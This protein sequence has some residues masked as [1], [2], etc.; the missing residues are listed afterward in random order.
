MS[1]VFSRMLARG[2]GLPVDVVSP[3]LCELASGSADAFE[4]VRAFG[5]TLAELAAHGARVTP[6]GSLMLDS[7][8]NVDRA[9][10][11][12]CRVIW[13]RFGG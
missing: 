9:F 6:S 5:I 11:S 12:V 8:S 2:M 3:V 13:G 7:A 4:Q 1:E 10:V